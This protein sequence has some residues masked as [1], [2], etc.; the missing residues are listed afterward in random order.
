MARDGMANAERTVHPKRQ[1]W[2]KSRSN[3]TLRLY[4]AADL[5]D[6]GV[7]HV[8]ELPALLV[9][10]AVFVDHLANTHTPRRS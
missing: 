1:E 9:G 3:S 4:V 8:D 5:A 7:N 10:V 6:V 2:N